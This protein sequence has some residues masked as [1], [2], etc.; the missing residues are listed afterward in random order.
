MSSNCIK[1]VIIPKQN[2]FS[3]PLFQAIGAGTPF[4]ADVSGLISESHYW[5]QSIDSVAVE[6]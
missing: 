2:S 4:K 1:E 5:N 6:F 3:F